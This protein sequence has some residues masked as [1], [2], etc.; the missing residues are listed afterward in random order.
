MQAIGILIGGFVFVYLAMAIAHLKQRSRDWSMRSQL[1]LATMREQLKAAALIRQRAGQQQAA[2][3]GYRAFTVSQRVREAHNVVSF[4]LK[5]QDGRALPEFLPGQSVSLRV[6]VTGED[7][8]VERRYSLSSAPNSNCYRVTVK[9]VSDGK[10][11]SQLL[12]HLQVGATIDVEAPAGNFHLR[13]ESDR[14]A[15]LIASGIGVAPYVS[16]LQNT[17]GAESHQKLRLLYEVRDSFDH[18]MRN[19]LA[20]LA[21]AHDWLTI[22]TV[23]SSPKSDDEAGRDFDFAGAVDVKLLKSVLPCSNFDFYISGPGSLTETLP[24]QLKDWGVPDSNVFCNAFG[25]VSSDT[26]DTGASDTKTPPAGRISTAGADKK[27]SAKS[28][29]EKL[30]AARSTAATSLKKKV[31]AAQPRSQKAVPSKPSASTEQDMKTKGSTDGI[32]DRLRTTSKKEGSRETAVWTETVDDD[33]LGTSQPQSSA[34]GTLGCVT[35]SQSKLQLAAT[36]Q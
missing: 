34:E 26:D 18:A 17:A 12:D 21:A 28:S 3:Q 30:A 14:P 36:A 1:A 15:V 13:E 5:P 22:V 25:A 4:Y 32:L 35:T 8:P 7:K 19:E 10:V 20:A 29:T 33:F 24:Q 16:M 9:R 31:S 27:S 11:S 2:W 23:F 6:R